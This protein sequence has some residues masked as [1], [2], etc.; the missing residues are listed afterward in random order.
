MATRRVYRIFF[1][2]QAKAYEIYAR[3]VSQSEIYGFVEVEEIIF[4]EKSSIVVDPSEESLKN[5]FGN[6]RKLLIPFHSISR[7]DEVEKEG[8][9]KVLSMTGQNA[10]P[11]SSSF[12]PP[13]KPSG[14][15][16]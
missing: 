7:I 15:S 11:S 13:K 3:K 4:G 12:F 6:V 9:G 16:D 5:E 10:S 8:P 2:S 14:S 1:T